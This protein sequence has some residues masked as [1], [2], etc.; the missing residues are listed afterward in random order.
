MNFTSLR[1]AL[2]AL[3]FVAAPLLPLTAQASTGPSFTD[4]VRYAVKHHICLG[5]KRQSVGNHLTPAARRVHV[6]GALSCETKSILVTIDYFSSPAALH[7]T[8][9]ATG[10]LTEKVCQQHS[11]QCAVSYGGSWLFIG[12]LSSKVPAVIANDEKVLVADEALMTSA[13]IARG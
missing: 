4:L 10:F 7:A 8:T 3:T 1:R 2:V 5:T 6:V 11:N 12:L 13:A 9:S